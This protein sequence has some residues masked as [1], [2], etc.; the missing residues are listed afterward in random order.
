MGWRMPHFGQKAKP[1]SIWKP[2]PEHSIGQDLAQ[3]RDGV[4][5]CTPLITAQGRQRM[6]L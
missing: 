5:W 4:I 1:L 6:D 3:G 2:Q